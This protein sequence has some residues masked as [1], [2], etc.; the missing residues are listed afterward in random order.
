[1]FEDDDDWDD[2]L[3]SYGLAD[4]I[5]WFSLP[6]YLFRP[7]NYHFYDYFLE[8][9]EEYP[10]WNE[11]IDDALEW[12]LIGV[13]PW[14]IM[15]LTE[16]ALEDDAEDELDGYSLMRDRL[17]VVDYRSF[18]VLSSGYYP[19]RPYLDK[20]E[21]RPFLKNLP[22]AFFLDPF[23]SFYLCKKGGRLRWYYLDAYC[24]VG[25]LVDDVESIHEV[26]VD[27]EV[28]AER[29]LKLFRWSN[30]IL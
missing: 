20:I 24:S 19:R 14:S 7:V 22:K 1:L 16:E 8:E 27:T 17:L 2:Y 9:E 12:D 15:D 21:H 10:L 28:I 5:E 3:R 4:W 18:L 29:E 6:D 11:W 25:H 23:S 26:L 13:A 30:K